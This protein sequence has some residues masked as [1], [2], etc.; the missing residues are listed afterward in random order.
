MK[1]SADGF[2]TGQLM[3]LLEQ[4]QSETEEKDRTIQTL[5]RQCEM[6][7]VEIR[8][9]QEQKQ[10]TETDAWKTSLALEQK[11]RKLRA[12]EAE[13]RSLRIQLRDREEEVSDL[14]AKKKFG[15]F[16]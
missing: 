14:K 12:C 13:A 11:A 9:L 5:Q 3:S 7:D 8:S 16:R 15:F 1:G 10:K 4:L 6:K 2:S